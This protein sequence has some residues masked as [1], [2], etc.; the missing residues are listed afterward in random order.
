MIRWAFLAVFALS[1]V[2]PALGADVEKEGFDQLSISHLEQHHFK[3]TAPGELPRETTSQ[4]ILI[5]G[6]TQQCSFSVTCNEDGTWGVTITGCT[7]LQTKRILKLVE[8]V[9]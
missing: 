8:E 2:S 9:C 5:Q 1:L 7:S 6:I 3:I 4:Q